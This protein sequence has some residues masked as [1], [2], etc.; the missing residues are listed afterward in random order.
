MSAI[1]YTPEQTASIL[2]QYA[3]GVDLKVMATSVGK[4]E[5]S[6]IAKLTREGVYVSAKTT[7]AIKRVTKADMIAQIA[8]ALGLLP[9]Q[10][11]S[12]EK[13]SAPQLAMLA[14][15]ITTLTNEI[16]VLLIEA[17]DMVSTIKQL[18]MRTGEDPVSPL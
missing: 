6:V 4:S 16:K 14:A 3:Q 12:L 7:P 13:A 11:D 2:T 10:L 1:I 17:G 9:A 15:G 8:D 18:L 5:R